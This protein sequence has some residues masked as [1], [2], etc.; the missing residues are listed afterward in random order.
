MSTPSPLEQLYCLET[1]SS[2]F[3]T[4]TTSILD[5]VEYKLY[6]QTL[7]KSDASLLVEHLDKVCPC[8]IL[9]A[10]LFSTSA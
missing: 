1:S 3:P 9:V 8:I 4:Q 7:E 10:S 6:V 5:G 2:Q